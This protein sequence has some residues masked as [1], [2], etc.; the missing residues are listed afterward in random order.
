MA[1]SAI[2]S[3]PTAIPTTSAPSPS[4]VLSNG[5]EIYY[6]FSNSS[7]SGSLVADL[8]KGSPVFDAKLQNG[9]TV[10]N[11]ELH[12]SSSQ[13]QFLS[14]GEF[15]ISNNGLTFASWFRSDGSGSFARIFDF[16]NGQAS[17][18]IIMGLL[19][20]RNQLYVEVYYGSQDS[21]RWYSALTYNDNVWYHAAWVLNPTGNWTVYLDGQAIIHA[22]GMTYPNLI[23][24]SSNYLGRSNWG[25]DAYW[26]GA[27]RDFR[28]YN[29]I[30]SAAEVNLLFTTTQVN[31]S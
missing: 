10:V 9:A 5:L 11:R 1:P 21:R 23:A 13:S 29:R 22:T 26:N 24:R 4:S 6:P 19:E 15:T 2:P 18:N 12:L 31:L 27:F 17:D 28:M 25:V 7:V 20:T 8:A 16:G 3:L 30:M 14:V